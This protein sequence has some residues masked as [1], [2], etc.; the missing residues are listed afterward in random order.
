MTTQNINALLRRYAEGSAPESA[1]WRGVVANFTQASPIWGLDLNSSRAPLSIDSFLYLVDTSNLWLASAAIS[2]EQLSALLYECGT[3]PGGGSPERDR[4]AQA[5]AAASVDGVATATPVTLSAFGTASTAVAMSPA[6]AATMARVTDT[7]E[8]SF[9]HWIVL[10]YRLTGGELVAALGHIDEPHPGMM[11]R[12]AL[13][14][15]VES[16]VQMDLGN[17]RTIVNQAV[18]RAGGVQLA[19]ELRHVNVA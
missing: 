6:Y 11:E 1:F 16:M 18:K 2:P 3:G 10:L 15:C 12:N 4:A 7:T 14:D 5:L 9:H 8:L 19:P 13:L 17:I